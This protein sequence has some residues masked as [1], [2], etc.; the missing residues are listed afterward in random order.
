MK[1]DITNRADIE[2]LIDTFYPKATQDPLIGHFFTHV[3][4]MDWEKHLPIMYTFWENALFFSG[5]YVGNMMDIHR[6]VHV[7]S[8]MTASHFER[9]TTL[10]CETVDE[11]FEGE[12]AERAKQRALGMATMLQIKLHKTV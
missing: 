2:L 7:K 4:A 8:S 1:T 6:A 5:G 12:N 11:L 10:F 3:V 9:W